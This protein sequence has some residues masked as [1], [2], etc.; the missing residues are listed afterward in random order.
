MDELHGV[1]LSILCSSNLTPEFRLKH[2][3]VRHECNGFG[4]IAR[5]LALLF[6]AVL[7]PLDTEHDDVGAHRKVRKPVRVLV[8]D[9]RFER[10]DAVRTAGF[11]VKRLA[12][13]KSVLVFTPR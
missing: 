11:P 7:R 8:D 2:Q 9:A 4:R 13:Q 12:V 3:L 10:L 6:H 5:I 1:C